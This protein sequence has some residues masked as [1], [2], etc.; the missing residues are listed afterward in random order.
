MEYKVNEEPPNIQINHNLNR[1]Y[2]FP[3]E[4]NVATGSKQLTTSI[5]HMLI[6]D[7]VVPTATRLL[8]E[9]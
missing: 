5:S 1:H 3:L 2:T 7:F 9:I 4:V 8:P 6:K